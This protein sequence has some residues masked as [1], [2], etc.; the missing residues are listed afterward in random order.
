MVVDAHPVL[1]RGVIALLDAQRGMTIVAEVGSGHDALIALRSCEPDVIVLGAQLPDGTGMEVCRSLRRERPGVAVLIFSA[2]DDDRARF[3]AVM[4]GASGYLLKDTPAEELVDAIR[5]VTAGESLFDPEAASALLSRLGNEPTQADTRLARLKPAELRILHLISHGHT[6]RQIASRVN[7]S[8]RTVKK[9]VSSILVKLGVP[10]RAGAAAYLVERVNRAPLSSAPRTAILHGITHALTQLSPEL[11]PEAVAELAAAL[12]DQQAVQEELQIQSEQLLADRDE[13]EAQRAY[14]VDLYQHAP[15]P[16][17]VTDSYGLITQA[18]RQAAT[19]L[20]LSE[21]QLCRRSLTAFV[22]ISARQEF[23]R[24]L[25]GL[26]GTIDEDEWTFPLQHPPVQITAK[27]AAARESSTAT[28]DLRWI[29]HACPLPQ[30]P[31][32]PG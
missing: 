16:Y 13:L 28:T 14:Y 22:P 15:V 5:R 32:E 3:D 9:Y 2:L 20:G 29:L 19:L 10:G 17:L 24:H 11:V 7:L 23:R 1:R 12:E 25:A 4:A 30:P 27:V 8:E 21:A 18:N 6:N 26:E 31:S